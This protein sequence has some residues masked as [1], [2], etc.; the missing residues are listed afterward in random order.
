MG[1]KIFKLDQ[2][3]VVGW[4]MIYL[5]LNFTSKVTWDGIIEFCERI[6]EKREI[7]VQN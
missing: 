4:H 3:K 5:K 6:K 2:F 1:E 7:W